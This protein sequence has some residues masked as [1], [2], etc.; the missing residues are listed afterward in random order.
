MLLPPPRVGG[1]DLEVGREGRSLHHLGCKPQRLSVPMAT[2]LCRGP[3]GSAVPGGGPGCR[4]RE[5]QDP[6]LAEP[7]SPQAPGHC[8][9]GPGCREA[10]SVCRLGLSPSPGGPGLESKPGSGYPLPNIKD[11]QPTWADLPA[12][13]AS[14]PSALSQPLPPASREEGVVTPT[15]GW[16]SRRVRPSSCSAP[17]SCQ[18]RDAALERA[19]ELGAPEPPPPDARVRAPRTWGWQSARGFCGHLTAE[20]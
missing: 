18:A 11:S 8:R 4:R 5:S 9:T 6:G 14:L 2:R 16:M 17:G 10:G 15:L 20:L 19:G 7:W 3:C 1:G 12:Q 13:P